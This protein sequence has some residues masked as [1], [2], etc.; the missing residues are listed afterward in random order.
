VQR[1]AVLLL[2]LGELD[3]A[4]VLRHMEPKEVQKSASPWPP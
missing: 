1:A 3:A 4:E 2:S